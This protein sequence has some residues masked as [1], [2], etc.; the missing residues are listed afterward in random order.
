MYIDPNSGGMLFQ[1]AAVLFGIA[2]GT[3]ILFS[4]TIRKYFFRIKR[5]LRERSEKK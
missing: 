2:S 1:I 3:V 4:G 5:T